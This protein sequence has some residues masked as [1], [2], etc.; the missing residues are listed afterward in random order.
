[1]VKLKCECNK[2]EAVF[3]SLLVG[4]SKTDTIMSAVNVVFTPKGIAVKTA[5]NG[6]VGIIANYSKDY[7]SSYDCA[8][9]ENVVITDTMLNALSWNNG[10]MTTE[11]ELETNGTNL[12]IK[13]LT[14][15]FFE[16]L[17]EL[18]VSEFELP[19]V[20][21]DKGLLPTGYVTPKADQTSDKK[22][23]VMVELIRDSI[24]LPDAKQL[25]EN[26]T[27][28]SDGTNLKIVLQPK[29]GKAFS[30][31]TTLKLKTQE[32]LEPCE[33]TL[34]KKYF[35]T[36]LSNADET[37]WLAYSQSGAVLVSKTIDSVL[38]YTLTGISGEELPVSDEES[39]DTSTEA[40]VED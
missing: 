13:G 1:M 37:F 2:L 33:I 7:F 9:P 22:M 24:K 18:D 29:D 10:G 30:W 36:A 20:S 21:T 39:S 40:T 23:R 6:L 4:K 3:K 27:I 5:H 38:T 19:V 26:M 14:D 17:I 16:A 25:G 28:V 15:D 8:K 11:V 32:K 34:N 35:T 12:T 31:S